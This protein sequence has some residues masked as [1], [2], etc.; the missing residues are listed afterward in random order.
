MKAATIAITR[1][2]GPL[3]IVAT[4]APGVATS[5]CKRA[6]N[7]SGM[8]VPAAAASDAPGAS[9]L[10]GPAVTPAPAPQTDASQ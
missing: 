9:G 1:R 5:G 10:T 6:D 7:T 8:R 4:I 2:C 3:L